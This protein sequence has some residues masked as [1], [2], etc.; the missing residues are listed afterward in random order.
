[1]ATKEE[2]RKELKSLVSDGIDT[3]NA[4]VARKR[5][6]DKAKDSV[7]DDGFVEFKYEKWYTRGLSIL[8]QL[9]PERIKDFQQLYKL[10]RRKENVDYSTYT[11][12][13]YLL[14]LRTKAYGEFVIGELQALEIFSQK[15]RNQIG[16]I[17]SLV[18][19][20]DSVL[21]D[22]KGVLQAELFDTELAAAEELLKNNHIRPA[23]VLAGVSLEA[24]LKTI[25]GNHSVKI[26]QKN[27]TISNYND[28][29][30]NASIYD[31]AQWRF[32]QHLG[33]LR[34]KCAH[35]GTV[36]PTKQ[37]AQ[38][39]IDGVKKVIKIVF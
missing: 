22:I 34:N 10:E 1:M 32:I 13:D 6:Q 23:G 19:K 38:D 28:E 21:S 16:I 11:I 4:E 3:L 2:F 8:Q 20:L 25:C 30:K 17:I 24:H 29:L 31:V 5:P 39:L 9:A 26:T 27:P 36:E 33:D 15:F 35:K 18:D 37:D 12:S 7:S 14:G